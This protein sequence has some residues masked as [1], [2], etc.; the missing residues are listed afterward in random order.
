MLDSITKILSNI[1]SYKQAILSEK[2]QL[3]DAVRA[4]MESTQVKEL[5]DLTN[6]L[7][8][9]DPDLAGIVRE[10]YK[11]LVD[12]NVKIKP[13]F[14]GNQCLH[15]GKET[16]A[17][18]WSDSFSKFHTCETCIQERQKQV[19]ENWQEEQEERQ[20]DLWALKTMPYQEYL[21]TEHWKMKRQ[22]ALKRAYYRCQLCNGNGALDVHH[23]T[24]ERRGE[25]YAND[26]IVLCRN[27]HSIFH[28]ESEVASE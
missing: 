2:E 28:A 21:K 7:Y 27:C 24:Y 12:K 8:W 26:L 13:A 3:K 10:T 6:E 16:P 23:R 4:Y 11:R 22:A 5:D 17:T 25:E 1:E 9:L 19:K 14:I 18:S 15:C 20:S